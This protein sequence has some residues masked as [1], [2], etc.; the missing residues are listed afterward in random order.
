MNQ[1][2][3]SLCE[4]NGA[5]Y[6]KLN[7]KKLTKKQKARL[8]TLIE[9]DKKAK[10]K[11]S[12]SKT[13]DWGKFDL[14]S[15]HRKSL[16]RLE[17]RLT[18]YEANVNKMQEFNTD[19][20]L[21]PQEN[22]IKNDLE[23]EAFD[24]G[25]PQIKFTNRMLRKVRLKKGSYVK[26]V[27]NCAALCFPMKFFCQD[28]RANLTVFVGY[29]FIP[30]TLK[31]DLEIE[32]ETSF[33]LDGGKRPHR[34]RRVGFMIVANEDLNSDMGCAFRRKKQRQ[35]MKD[36]QYG[37]HLRRKRAYLRRHQA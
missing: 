27:I 37:D 23:A 30:G 10:K 4:G 24:K 26:A 9:K 5:Q 29:N 18:H 21:I 17:D 16:H 14:F 6:A 15:H 1:R 3:K 8:Q 36:L 11:V 31:F 19:L 12:L 25:G 35:M 22:L 13:A 7:P 34:V 20:N 2:S 28:K 33:F 32:D